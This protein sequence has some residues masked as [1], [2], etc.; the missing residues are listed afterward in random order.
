MGETD[1]NKKE[2]IIETEDDIKEDVEDLKELSEEDLRAEVIKNYELDE[3]SQS[4]LIDKLVEKEKTSRKKLGKAIGQKIKYREKV[5]KEETPEEKEKREAKEKK[6]KEK[7]DGKFVTKEDMEERDLDDLDIP[8][9]DIRKE[10]QDLAKLKKVS[11]KQA[12]KLPYIEALVK[13]AKEKAE[14]EGAGLDSTGKPKPQKGSKDF[15]RENPREGLDMQ[16]K[17]GIAEF[18]RRSAVIHDENKEKED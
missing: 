4:D 6:D 13:E 7:N 2:E 10:V 14:E 9:D 16:T 18:E 12:Y 17:E 1:P 11:V 5:P 3:D 8:N 15:D